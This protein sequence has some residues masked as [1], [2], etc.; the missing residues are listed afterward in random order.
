MLFRSN[1]LGRRFLLGMQTNYELGDVLPGEPRLRDQRYRFGYNTQC[2]GFQLEVL[3][4]NFLGTSQREFRFLINLKGVGNVID[5][6]SG[7]SGALPGTFP[8][9]VP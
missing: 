4:R 3:N 5:F 8:G 2:C 1:F 7:S 6:Q 9:I